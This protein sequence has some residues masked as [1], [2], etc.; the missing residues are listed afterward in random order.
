MGWAAGFGRRD[1]GSGDHPGLRVQKTRR[2]GKLYG[3]AT[4]EDASGKIELIV[5]PR[6]YEKLGPQ[7]KIEAPVLL[8]GVLSG[9]EDA[10]PKLA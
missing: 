10:A 3:Q 8:R 9:E 5:F 4:L 7:M 6:D 2:E 1:S